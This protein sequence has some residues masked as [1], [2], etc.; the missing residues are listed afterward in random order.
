MKS[1]LANMNKSCI[2]PV[3]EAVLNL[4]RD[5]TDKRLSFG[6]TMNEEESELPEVFI[7]IVAVKYFPVMT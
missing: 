6:E 7:G 2:I 4:A 1:A 5:R 3:T